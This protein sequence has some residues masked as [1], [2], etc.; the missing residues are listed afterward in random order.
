MQHV[1]PEFYEMKHLKGINQFINL[2]S[3]KL[4]G[5]KNPIL[6]YHNIVMYDQFNLKYVQKKRN[7]LFE[8][9]LISL[10]SNK[11]V[12]LLNLNNLKYR[13]KIIYFGRI[14]NEQKDIDKLIAINDKIHLIDFYGNGEESL[15]KKLGDSYK[16]KLEHKNMNEILQKYK[17]SILLS[18]YEGFSFSLVESLSNGLPSILSNTYQSAKFLIDNNHNGLLIEKD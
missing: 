17:F 14:E 4:F 18:K 15:I 11:E 13:K 12:N 10:S 2:F 16:G 9:N 5:M 1:T 7:D 8:Y 6:N 3:T